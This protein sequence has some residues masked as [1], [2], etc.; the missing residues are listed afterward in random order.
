[1][2]RFPTGHGACLL[3]LESRGLIEMWKRVEL[4]KATAL[5]SFDEA[6]RQI[7]AV[8]AAAKVRLDAPV[9]AELGPIVGREVLVPAEG[10]ETLARFADGG[11]AITRHKHGAGTVWVVG[12]FPGLE[13]SAPLR[14]AR[15]D[16]GRD[17]R[18]TLRQ[19]VT[20]PCQGRVRPV[21]HCDD[22]AV[23]G[24]LLRNDATGKLAVTLMNWTY[25]AAE[26]N[27][28]AKSANPTVQL[29]PRA[30][31]KL[32]IRGTGEIANV[33]SVATAQAVAANYAEDELT[34]TLPRLDEGEVLLLE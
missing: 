3:G 7:A 29:V 19:F 31:V 14:S 20:L 24:V 17:L 4:Y 2:S 33:R 25:R 26:S 16:M 27:D 28:G 22:P 15:Y 10:T 11:A 21:V 1:M 6:A 32:R 23:E 8:P 18:Q 34:L 5:E 30:N 12:L 13:Y 9:Q